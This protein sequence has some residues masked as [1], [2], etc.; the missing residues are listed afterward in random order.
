MRQRIE[1]TLLLYLFIVIVGS[2]G[3]AFPQSVHEIAS[4]LDEYGGDK[5]NQCPNTRTGHFHTYKD[6]AR[7]RWWL[8]DPDGNRFI[9]NAV[10]DIGPFTRGNDGWP[11][12]IL[13]RYGR[14]RID[15]EVMG[16]E[17]RRIQ[18]LGFNTIGEVSSTYTFPFRTSSGAGN[19]TRLP[20]LLIVH[21]SAGYKG[22]GCDCPFHDTLSVTGP[23]FQ[24][25]RPAGFPDVWDPNWAKHAYYR[26]LRRNN[27]WLGPGALRSFDDLDSSPYYLGT[28]VE[29]S[30]QTL[31][32]KGIVPN[33]P[34]QAWWIAI[35]PPRQV[36]S[37]RFGVIYPDPVMHGK[38][39]FADWLQG[40]ADPTPIKSISRKSN[41]VTVSFE[42]CGSDGVPPGPCS[43]TNYQPFGLNE[44]VNLSG[45]ADASFNQKELKVIN[46]TADSIRYAQPGPDASSQ[47]GVVTSGPS[48]SLEALNAAWGS[49]YTTFGSTGE[50]VT[51][52]VVGMGDGKTS[53]FTRELSQK[54]V[55]AWSVIVTID[56]QPQGGDCPWF[57]NVRWQ[58]KN[59]YPDDCGKGLAPATGVIQGVPEQSLIS[60]GTI[61]YAS[62]KLTLSFEKPPGA[63]TPIAV[64]YYHA[65]WPKAVAHG[66]GFL[67]E[68]GTSPWMP[69]LEVIR[70]ADEHPDQESQ[71]ER[72]FDR[73]LNHI[74]QRYFSVLVGAVHS[75][76]PHKLVL[77]PNFMGPYD[78]APVLV[79]AGQ[80]LDVLIL[81]ETQDENQFRLPPRA[82][83]L[84]QK[85]VIFSEYIIGN[86]DSATPRPCQG[87]DR[88]NG[89]LPTQA[90]R[91]QTYYKRWTN[92]FDMRGSDGYGFMIGWDWWRLFDDKAEGQNYGLETF[93]GNLYDGVEARKQNGEAAD[94][95]DFISS[96][97]RAN[98]Y[99]LEAK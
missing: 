22:Q 19:P 71:L 1:C 51:T 46:Q 18:S 66:T 29:D 39:E 11:K 82:Y 68:D 76:V 40:K 24:G 86:P 59:V 64:N 6:P 56:G 23:V 49:K 27:M 5:L 25:W 35:D 43:N 69:P 13:Q 87:T 47:G 80:Y 48:Y 77:G 53:S 98:V 93:V 92:Y 57:D 21:P 97:R 52:E 84:A 79:Q 14:A 55:D 61:D 28:A 16:L 44:I 15:Y 94:Y 10:A 63:R 89:C 32:F 83:D 31:G 26:D 88:G 8:C 17:L 90:L 99:W 30:D 95:G 33:P 67:D 12:N 85:P 9:M 81:G 58:F 41:T 74:A 7:K 50:A 72:D 91:G 75:A 4:R 62:G 38:Q 36:W 3:T 60:G 65:G 42:K 45:V 73:F 78:H 70:A 20:V 2:A 34:H 54:P 37:G 96:V